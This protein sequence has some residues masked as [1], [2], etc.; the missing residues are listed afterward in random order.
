MRP[1]TVIGGYGTGR[2]GVAKNRTDRP[3]SVP[4]PVAPVSAE[5]RIY[6]IRGERVMLDSDLAAVYGVTTGNLNKAVDRNEDRF[7]E[8]FSF[9]LTG[10][11]WQ[12]LIFQ[13]GTS[14]SWGGRRKLPRV[15]TE[16]G[17]VMLASVLNSPRAVAASIQVVHAFV[18]LRRVLDA[19]K[20][21]A[22]RIDELNARLDKKTGEDAVR[23]QAIFREL[24]R[25]ALGYEAEE[26]RPKGRIGF[27]TNQERE[28]ERGKQRGRMRS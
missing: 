24:K 12:N 27:K 9:K 8:E 1:E 15:F 13:S 18:R 11:E 23:F 3:V 19:N 4:S 10:V 2:K 17:A 14:S 20:E 26:A 25:L 16:H 5:S 21:L 7:P 6:M 28:A 22:R